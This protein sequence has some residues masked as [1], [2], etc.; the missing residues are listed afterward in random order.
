MC[1]APLPPIE[2]PTS[3]T[4]RRK[5]RRLAS[6]TPGDWDAVDEA[7]SSLCLLAAAADLLA[8][9]VDRKGNDH[10]VTDK[11]RADLRALSRRVQA[12]I[13]SAAKRRHLHVVG[14]PPTGV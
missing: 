14:E 5:R 10:L 4:S 6:A 11:F 7:V 9:Q 3:V 1:L 2:N 8:N 12:E 13:D